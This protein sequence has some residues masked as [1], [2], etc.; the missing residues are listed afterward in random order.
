MAE[1]LPHIRD[2]FELIKKHKQDL[3]AQ[4]KAKSKSTDESKHAVRNSKG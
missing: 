3:E 4:V 1:C 2:V